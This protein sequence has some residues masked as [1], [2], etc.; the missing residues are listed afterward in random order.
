MVD[1]TIMSVNILKAKAEMT[2]GCLPVNRLFGVTY[3]ELTLNPFPASRAGHVLY[4]KL[5]CVNRY[6]I[7]ADR[8]DTYESTMQSATC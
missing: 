6:I 8:T 1:A 2:D 4:L 7:E 3:E 5:G